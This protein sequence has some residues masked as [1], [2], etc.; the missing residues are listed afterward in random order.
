MV[1]ATAWGGSAESAEV[2]APVAR[3]SGLAGAS[4][5]LLAIARLVLNGPSDPVV[6]TLALSGVGFAVSAVLAHRKPSAGVFLLPWVGMF[7]VF[8]MALFDSGL[9]SEALPWAPF[10]AM[11]IPVCLRGIPMVSAAVVVLLLPCVLL[12]SAGVMDSASWLRWFG[13]EG[14]LIFGM[15]LAR[16]FIRWRRESVSELQQE[17]SRL[18]FVIDNLRS[19]IAVTNRE[20]LVVAVNARLLHLFKFEK[21]SVIGERFVKLLQDSAKSVPK[22]EGASDGDDS[23]ALDQVTVGDR[24]Y[25]VRCDTHGTEETSLVLWSFHEVTRRHRSYAEALGRLEKDALTGLYN[26]SHLLRELKGATSSEQP[27]ALLFID[28][29]G[30][31]PI[32][33]SMGHAAGDAIL[34]TVASRLRAVMRGGDVVCRLGGDEFCVITYGVRDRAQAGVIAEKIIAALREPYKGV[35]ALGSSV[36][37]A[38]YPHVAR[39]PDSLL[40]RA[41]VAMYAAKRKG[42][43]RWAMSRPSMDMETVA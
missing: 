34:R 18:Q 14:A 28:L 13:I 16:A 8:G 35:T 7:G 21:Q 40:H 6:Y 5:I 11:L 32:N 31:K 41:D 33:D 20:G 19:G 37:V 30:F 25:E 23:S 29:D 9:Q 24:V 10:V 12:F 2:A 4:A 39:H 3:A 26:R 15:G 22:I 36:G 1:L 17:H 42:G 27:F 43:N 38:L